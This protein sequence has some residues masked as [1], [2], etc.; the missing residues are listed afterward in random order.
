MEVSTV[1]NNSLIN[2]I[3]TQPEFKSITFSRYK[4]TE[5]KNQFIENMLKGKIEPACYWCAEFVCAGHYAEIW[6][7]IIFYLG[8]HIHIGNPKLAIYLEKRYTIFKNI[9]EKGHFVSELELRNNSTIRRLFA[10]VICV[11]TLSAKHNSFETVKIK[12]EDEFDIT[13]IADKLKA[14]SIT[15]VGPIFRPRDPKELLIP[16][17]EFAYH[18]GSDKKNMLSACYWIE[19]IIEFDLICRKT[20]QPVYCERR[21][22]NVENKSQCDI[23]WLIWDVLVYYVK[24][25]KNPF[26]E[27]IMNSLL[28]I[29]CIKYTTASCKRRKYLLYF[30]VEIMTNHVPTNIELF[31]NKEVIYSVVEKIDQIYAQIKKNEDSPNTDYLFSNLDSKQNL[32]SSIKKM[33]LLSTIDLASQEL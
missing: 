14:D 25:R 21:M 9:L 30:A 15:F 22:N 23:I 2:D 20:K 1:P 33:E 17:N 31:Q 28:N 29:F 5:V 19:W 32:E 26:I 13:Q 27:N 16:I 6:E 3:R 11:L 4:K 12:R 8:K 18:I 7:D 10:E 24:Q